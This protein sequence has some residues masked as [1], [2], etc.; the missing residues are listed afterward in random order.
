[1]FGTEAFFW[2]LIG[3]VGAEVVVLFGLRHKDPNDFP[4]WV[5]SPAYYV[6]A[7]VMAILGGAITVAHLRSGSSMDPILAIQVGAS[8]PLILRKM[9]DAVPSDESPD[10]SRI[11]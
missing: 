11:D 7:L 8:A 5:R 1:M 4:Y 10:P 6:I 3:G 9:R 2:G